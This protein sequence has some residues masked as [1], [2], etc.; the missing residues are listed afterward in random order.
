[1]KTRSVPLVDCPNLYFQ[2][3]AKRNAATGCTEWQGATNNKGY[4]WATV[5]GDQHLAHRLSYR[6]FI[7]EL[8]GDSFVCHTCDN[9]K[10][11]NPSHLFL[12]TAADNARDRDKKERGNWPGMS[13]ESHPMCK[14]SDADVAEIKRRL[15][16]GEKQRAVAASYGVSQQ[17]ISDIKRGKYRA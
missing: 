1:M 11:V 16:S 7:G 15:L 6:A 17:H 3:R 2:K 8:I 5:K 12:G 14:I 4:G 9:P 10:C 13:G